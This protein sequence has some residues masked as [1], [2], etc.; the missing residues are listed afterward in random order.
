MRAP[1]AARS[2]RPTGRLTR[3]WALGAALTTAALA[4]PLAACGAS[5]GGGTEQA[6]PT[7]AQGQIEFWQWGVSYIEGFDKLAAEFNEKNPGARV[8]HA[9]QDGLQ[10]K[11]KVSVA[12]GSGGFDAYLMRGDDQRQW[13]HEGIAVDL[14]QYVTRDKTAA[15]DVKLTLKSFQDHV[16]YK[17]KWH[18]IPWDLSTISVAYNTQALDA[19][20]LKLP[21]ELGAGWTWDTF[22]EYARRLN[23]GDGS[24]YGVD[25]SPGIETGYYNWVVANGGAF[26]S[27]DEQRVTV[28]SPAFAEAVE[29]YMALANRLQVSPPRAWA[30]EQQRPLPHRAHFLVN[31][32]V[33]MQTVGDWF[34]GWFDRA[35][36]LKWDAV[37][38]PLSPRTKKTG[39]IANFRSL[40]VPPTAQHKDLAWAWIAFLLKKDVQDRIPPLMTEVPARVDSIDAVYLNPA[41]APTPKSRTLLKAAVDATY[42]LPAHPLITRPD[43]NTVSNAMND[44]YDGKRQAKEVLAEMQDKLTALLAKS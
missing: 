15:A 25:A 8:I 20:G 22:T 4:T 23:P 32:L 13:A 6:A 11:I 7:R 10:D 41:K 27:E 30:T 33:A 44:V 24:K 37:P 9:R 1:A 42:T 43:I 29:A 17:G 36:Q 18:G 39:S 2:G 34:F 40:A 5:G 35:P 28:N 19:R 26:F 38:M 31:G 21:S 12:A 14:S 3:R 16:Q